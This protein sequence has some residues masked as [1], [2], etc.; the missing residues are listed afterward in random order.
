MLYYFS[1]YVACQRH[2]SWVISC[3]ITCGQLG[4]SVIFTS[5]AV[6]AK[7]FWQYAF[8]EI[9]EF[10]VTV[11][12]KLFLKLY[13]PRRILAGC[14]HYF[15]TSLLTYLLNS[16]EHS[17]SW[18]ANRF[19]ASQEIPRILWNPKVHYRILMCPPPV[20]ILSQLNPFHTPTHPTNL[21]SIFVVSCNLRRCSHKY[22]YKFISNALCF[23]Q[24]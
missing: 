15:L 2:V 10:F 12:T 24:F 16:M 14:N 17:L 22:N 21:K 23:V 11:P 13:I 19:S 7:F 5:F 1:N 3:Y 8:D 6:N 9:T 18:E 4:C 20:H